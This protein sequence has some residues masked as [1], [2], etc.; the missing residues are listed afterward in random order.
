MTEFKNRDFLSQA[1]IDDLMRK[2]VEMLLHD[3]D[4]ITA[5]KG[6]FTERTGILLEI[7]N[8]RARLSRSESRGTLF[9]CIGEFLWY[10]SGVNDLNSIQYYLSGYHEYSDDGETLYGAYGPRL[11]FKLSN[12]LTQLQTIIKLLKSKNTSRRAVI[13]LYDKKDATKKTKDLPCT[14]T[15]QFLNRHDR[16]NMVT[17]MRSNDAYKGL[18]HDVFAFTMIQEF[19]ARSVKVDVGTYK[20]MVGSLHL[21]DED[22]ENAQHFLNE[23]WMSNISMPE[24]PQGSP[25]M[26]MRTVLS[27]EKKIRTGIRVDLSKLELDDYW[28]DIV[29]LLYIF[30]L[31]KD[32][33]VN[34][35]EII[36]N[37]MVS[38]TYKPY[39]ERR[40][41]LLNG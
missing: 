25:G 34:G 4:A 30:K 36:A 39:I 26:S 3:V 32:K 41:E 33:D 9:S 13:Q 10:M 29:R 24:M 40:F 14:C 20:H 35:I 6:K 2:V 15:L 22:R 28:M 38:E 1:S 27:L 8:P 18:P 23:G 37:Q 5:T 19:V 16:L 12:G 31:Y 17:N 21:Y 11:L 7:T